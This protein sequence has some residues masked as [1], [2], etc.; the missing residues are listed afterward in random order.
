MVSI[1]M[2]E[3]IKDQIL[4]PQPLLQENSYTTMLF[5]QQFSISQVLWHLSAYKNIFFKLPSAL[6]KTDQN[7]SAFPMWCVSEMSL[8][9]S[10]GDAPMNSFHV[11]PGGGSGGKE[12]GRGD[13]RS[14]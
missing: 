6:P 10:A 2:D 5:H 11:L 14:H 3:L 8:L 13:S 7:I 4:P 9:S 1:L 12:G